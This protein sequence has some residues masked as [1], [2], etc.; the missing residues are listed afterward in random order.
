MPKGKKIQDSKVVSQGIVKEEE[1]VITE[2]EIVEKESEPEPSKFTG[3]EEKIIEALAL[4]P[5]V[6]IGDEFEVAEV[7]LI[8]ALQ[9][10]CKKKNLEGEEIITK[11][12]STE[13]LNPDDL[14]F[15]K[16]IYKIPR[17][18]RKLERQETKT[19]MEFYKMVEVK[20]Q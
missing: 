3:K 18:G 9:I 15:T 17:H 11:V 20:E 5:F 14:L 6:K 1:H 7:G 19:L 10:L 12:N 4:K 8:K 16:V 13:E 2:K